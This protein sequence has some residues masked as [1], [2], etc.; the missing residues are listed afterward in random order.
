MKSEDVRRKPARTTAVKETAK[1]VCPL[2]KPEGGPRSAGRLRLANEGS[3]ASEDE[4]AETAAPVAR[5]ARRPGRLRDTRPA[6]C[7]RCPYGGLCPDEFTNAGCGPE[8][9]KFA[10]LS[11]AGSLPKLVADALRAEFRTYFRAKKLETTAGGKIDVEASKML[12]GILRAVESYLGILDRTDARVGASGPARERPTRMH[13]SLEL[14]LQASGE[15]LFSEVRDEALRVRLRRAYLE[16]IGAED[17]V[18][19]AAQAAVGLA[20]SSDV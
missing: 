7:E 2:E 10:E 9:D 20:P 1:A 14:A 15:S 6:D 8:R 19:R 4:A 5:A 11:S 17:A 12:Q 13:P 16:A 18:L 3:R